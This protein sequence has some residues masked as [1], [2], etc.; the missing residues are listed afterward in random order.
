MKFVTTL[1]IAILAGLPGG[2]MATSVSTH[3]MFQGTA[4]DAVE[5]YRLVFPTFV[6]QRQ[7]LHEEGEQEGKLRLA[8]VKF[9]DHDLIVFDSAP[10]HD[11]TFT[12]SMSLFVEFDDEQALRHAFETMA[13]GGAVAMPLGDYGFSPLFGW[14]QDRHR[15]SWQL[16]LKRTE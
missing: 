4:H 11:F 6:V 12:P 16:S 1:L 9:S 14:L 8:H 3:L 2:S 10:V 7:E 5:L 13:E 15:V